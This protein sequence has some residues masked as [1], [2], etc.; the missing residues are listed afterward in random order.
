MQARRDFGWVGCNRIGRTSGVA[1]RALLFVLVCGCPEGA[2]QTDVATQIRVDRLIE[3]HEPTLDLGQRTPVASSA[4]YIATFLVSSPSGGVAIFDSTG[5]LTAAFARQGSG[6]GEFSQVVSIG[7]GS[8]DSLVVVD[9]YF[10]V[11]FFAPPPDL[12]FVRTAIMTRPVV[13]AP[14]P[15]GV[16]APAF[17]QN[18][19]VLP[20]MLVGW[21]GRVIRTYGRRKEQSDAASAMGA[22][23]AIGIDSI[24]SASGDTYHLA[25][26]DGDGQVRQIITREVEWFPSTPGPVGFS[27]EVRPNPRIADLSYDPDGYL[28]VLIRRAHRNWKPTANAPRTSDG[29]VRLHQLRRID[30]VE[31]FEY[32]L[33]VF[34]LPEGDL[35]ASADLEG[36]YSGFASTTVLAGREW[37]DDGSMRITL[38]R[39]SLE[40]R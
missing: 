34:S 14:S 39:I 37:A 4:G 6:P 32:V 27:W 30:E 38:N 12:R 15:Q 29:P 21:D 13:G 24:W 3:L 40:R 5:K 17:V 9:S 28:W 16:L 33:E 11:H 18:G 8:G 7:F 25:L 31:R 19:A 36:S 22:V 26:V 1:A 2:H 20:P 35:L 10:R 23:D